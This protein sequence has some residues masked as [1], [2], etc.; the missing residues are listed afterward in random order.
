MLLALAQE[1]V[2]QDAEVAEADHIDLHEFFGLCAEAEGTESPLLVLE[3]YLYGIRHPEARAELAPVLTKNQDEVAELVHRALSDGET[4]MTQT[5]EDTAF[6]L[7][8]L[9][10][11]G[12]IMARLAPDTQG[13]KDTASTVDRLIGRLLAS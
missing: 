8:A 2:A 11:Y 13:Y 6:A 3:L 12:S 10:T 5:D 9:H 1:L 7:V 4:E